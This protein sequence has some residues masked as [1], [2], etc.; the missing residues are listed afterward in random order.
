MESNMIR[1]LPVIILFLLVGCSTTSIEITD[2]NNQI[3]TQHYS[4]TVP[5]N[6]GWYQHKDVDDS[7]ILNMVK[8]MDPN[9][10][11]MRFSTNWV[12]DE[13]MKSWTTKQI[14]DEYRAGEEA[15]MIM[16]G[17]MSGQYELKDV[18]NGEENVGDKE[19]FTMSYTTISSDV[20]QR[21]FLY[22]YFPKKGNFKR[23]LVSLYSESS[24]FNNP[25][26]ESYK[27]EFL[28]TLSSLKISQ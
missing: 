17:V 4:I 27:S 11:L 23:F 14:A 24:P 21:A 2:A 22:L 5:A 8:V 26:T 16:M 3:H 28:E 10:Y 25:L 18:V 15:N 19:C 7:D 20:K 6:H 9:V 13:S 1:C 12:T